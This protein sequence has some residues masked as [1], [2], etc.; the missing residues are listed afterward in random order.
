MPIRILLFGLLLC[1][2][3]GLALPLHSDEQ[4]Q[5]LTQT[6]KSEDLSEI[7][8]CSFL[9]RRRD[10]GFVPKNWA[11]IA[12]GAVH[13]RKMP[14][15]ATAHYGKIAVIGTG[16]RL[17]GN[18]DAGEKLIK[19]DLGTDDGGHETHVIGIISSARYG[20]NPYIPV[21]PLAVKTQHHDE[22]VGLDHESFIEKLKQAIADPEV[23]IISLSVSFPENREVQQLIQQA[24]D[25]GKWIVTAMGNDDRANSHTEAGLQVFRHSD[26]FFAAG[27]YSF[28]GAPSAFT[29]PGKYY[30]PGSEVESLS[31]DFSPFAIETKTSESKNGTSMAT[32]HLAAIL[33]T[34]HGLAPDAQ[35]WQVHQLLLRSMIQR[36]ES[37]SFLQVND[38]FIGKL[39][40]AAKSKSCFSKEKGE[41]FETCL[42]EAE[43]QAN[44]SAQLPSRPVGKDCKDWEKYYEALTAGYFTTKGS[45]PFGEAITDF[46]R[47]LKKTR[48][49]ENYFFTPASRKVPMLHGQ[50]MADENV[51][52]D[53]DELKVFHNG[54]EK[55][56]DRGDFFRPQGDVAQALDTIEPSAQNLLKVMKICSGYFYEKPE[57]TRDRACSFYLAS[58]P[59]WFRVKI[60]DKLIATDRPLRNEKIVECLLEKKYGFSFG[61]GAI[62]GTGELEQ[63]DPST[64]YS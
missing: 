57:S 60:A 34:I 2:E 44:G 41:L 5:N 33:E 23:H 17:R 24:M 53:Y 13:L 48:W 8:D 56:R 31:S 64:R 32:P 50:R 49:A 7:A 28:F 39:T 18:P 55:T 43:K 9:E 16:L 26:A 6:K 22:K 47:D 52:R 1:S 36:G 35:P 15:I 11:L 27:A 51:E 59:Q 14:E 37:P 25:A 29:N 63:P 12:S 45:A 10:I 20:V 3:I 46:F 21:L 42:N 58:A 19:S 30:T 54:K 40:L 38:G 61:W 4:S 62:V